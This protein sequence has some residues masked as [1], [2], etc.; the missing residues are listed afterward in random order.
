[1]LGLLPSTQL[2]QKNNFFIWILDRR[3]CVVQKCALDTGEPGFF[4]FYDTV[5]CKVA[6]FFRL[7]RFKNNA[8]GIYEPT[9]STVAHSLIRVNKYPLGF[10]WFFNFYVNKA[11]FFWNYRCKRDSG[12]NFW[13][14]GIFHNKTWKDFRGLNQPPPSN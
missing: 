14:F 11:S 13:Q 10:N 1:M 2:F 7:Q 9:Y 4:L 12:D 8:R 3:K 6:P 5:E